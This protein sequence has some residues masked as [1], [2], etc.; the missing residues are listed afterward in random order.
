MLV[1]CQR[2]MKMIFFFS[3]LSRLFSF[4]R[5]PITGWL[6]YRTHF[7]WS[8]DRDWTRNLIKAIRRVTDLKAEKAN[9]QR[10]DFHVNWN[11]T[12]WSFDDPCPKARK[13]RLSHAM[14]VLRNSPWILKLIKRFCLKSFLRLH[15]SQ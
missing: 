15:A 12:R 14:E 13:S 5:K 4:P 1:G 3:S 11:L 10:R 7:I 6:V 9:Q 2:R 8:S